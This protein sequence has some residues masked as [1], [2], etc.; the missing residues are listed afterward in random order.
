M[1]VRFRF[2]P[3]ALICVFGGA[4]LLPAQI[5]LANGEPDPAYPY[6]HAWFDAATGVN[7]A[8][9]ANGDPVSSW[10]GRSA[11]QRSLPQ[12]GASQSTWPVWRATAAA[13]WPA[14]EF[15]G[16]AA[17]WGDAAAEFGTL[18]VARTILVVAYAGTGAD[19]RYVFDGSQVVGRNALMA[20]QASF[21]PGRWQVWTGTSAVVSTDVGYEALQVHTVSLASGSQQHWIDGVL[22]ATGQS[23]LNSLYGFTAGNRYTLDSGWVGLIAEILVY[24]ELLVQ[25]DREAIEA[26]LLSK[27][28][29]PR[30]VLAYD[31][32]V[33][34]APIRFEVTGCTPGRAVIVAASTFGPGPLAT[35]WGTAQLTPPLH[36]LPP[37]IADAG[38]LAFQTAMVPATAAGLTLWLQALDH[39][40]GTFS[41]LVIGE[42]Q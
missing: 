3:L 24:S 33:A 11:Q 4:P 34:G 27:Y 12:V 36:L 18:S 30:P 23:G 20:G 13:G 22:Q 40:S 41:G 21:N 10:T 2:W 17:I 32:L 38:G 19:Q 37:S 1:C 25:D 9:V 14:L 31:Q 7:G 35:R 39:G 5:V 6:L 29:A 16:D 28:L 42:V 8:P 15:D 26:Y